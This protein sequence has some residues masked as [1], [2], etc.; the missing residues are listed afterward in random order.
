MADPF[1]TMARG[2]F[3]AASAITPTAQGYRAIVDAG[4]LQ[5]RTAF[6]GLSA[7]MALR[8]VRAVVAATATNPDSAPPLRTIDVD[9]LGPIEA[10]ALTIDANVLRAG[11]AITWAE[12]IIIQNNRPALRL[13]AV[14]AATRPS[15]IAITPPPANPIVAASAAPAMPYIEGVVPRFARNY[16]LRLGSGAL[17]FQAGSA[18]HLD[19][20]VR[21]R[22]PATGPEALLGLLDA[23]PAPVLGLLAAPAPASTVR[24]SVQCLEPAAIATLDGSQLHHYRS[25]ALAA[26]DG[27]VV[28][29]ARIADANGRVLALSEQLVA[30]FD[31]R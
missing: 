2:D 15:A 13:R 5:G 31:Q 7:A 23:W 6:G 17:P 20:W 14:F 25:D 16:D 1:I 9:F 11:R 4:W 24:W 29:A 19:G 10:G 3:D 21:C 8:A 30:V 28:F 18:T 26:C 27:T 22:G 12:A